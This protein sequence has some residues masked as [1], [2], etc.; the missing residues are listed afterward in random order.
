MDRQLNGPPP[1]I[2]VIVRLPYNRPEEST[3]DPPAVRIPS[4]AFVHVT[5]SHEL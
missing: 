4:G 1:P 3:P 2:R 5:Q